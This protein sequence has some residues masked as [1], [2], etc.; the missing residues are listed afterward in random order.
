MEIRMNVIT[1]YSF[2]L[3][4]M[5]SVVAMICTKPR[6]TKIYYIDCAGMIMSIIE[7]IL[8]LLLARWIDISKSCNYR[9]FVLTYVLFLIG[10]LVILNLTF[11][12]ILLLTPELLI[13]FKYVVIAELVYD[14]GYCI[15][16]VHGLLTGKMFS[17][18]DGE[19]VITKYLYSFVNFGILNSLYGLLVWLLGR[20][21]MSRIVKVAIFVTSSMDTVL[22]LL[23]GY[24]MNCVFLSSTY[25]LTFLVFYVLFHSNPYNENAGCQNDYSFETRYLEAMYLHKDFTVIYVKLTQFRVN[26]ELDLEE[27]KKYALSKKSRQIEQI[28]FNVCNYIISDNEFA[29]FLKGSRNDK[30]AKQVDAIAKIF[31]AGV[32]YKDAMLYTDFKMIVMENNKYVK[33]LHELKKFFEYVSR[34]FQIDYINERYDCE[35]KD[36]ES[37]LET[38]SIENMLIDIRNKLDLDDERVL[39]YT[40]PIYCIKTN[41]FRTAEALMR[42]KMGDKIIYP[43]KFIDLAEKNGCIHALTCIILNKVCKEINMLSKS[44]DFDAI[45]INCSTVEM[46]DENLDKELIEI[47]ERNKVISS[48][49]RLELTESTISGNYDIVSSN[50]K[51]LNQAGVKFYLDDFGTG[52]SNLA[53][54]VSFPF[55]TIKFDKSILYRALSDNTMN[56]LLDGMV[57]IFKKK[58]FVLL[59]EGVEN[60]EHSN[61]SIEHGFDY[62]QGYKYAKPVPIEKLSEYFEKI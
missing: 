46:E 18:V 1:E 24:N 37:F 12:Y 23:Q 43:D 44:Y 49:I 32:L 22:L 13:P 55:M 31:A 27:Q 10:Y 26:G 33:S 16:M 28:T 40:Q 8:T 58:G 36:Y 59:I 14:V 25:V 17:L 30:V 2:L 51:K 6:R 21:N 20:K 19:I 29:I 61:Y 3:I 7:I 45:T 39:C 42:L 9:M 50:M 62:I 34:E 57:R 53:R 54:I 48:K 4:A 60:D 41:T 35:E 38:Y 11:N 56:D 47:I 15:F 5:L 52:Y